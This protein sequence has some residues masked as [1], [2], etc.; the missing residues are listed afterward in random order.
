MQLLPAFL[1]LLIDKL[2]S[3]K[4]SNMKIFS[5]IFL[6][7]LLILIL[8]ADSKACSPLNVPTL[9]SQSIS[10][11]NLV[12]NWSGNTIYTCGYYLQV[13]LACNT[14]A[15]TGTGVPAF[16]NTATVTPSS[17]PY[18]YPTQNI[19]IST[20]CA[21]TT[22]KFRAREVYPASTFSAWTATFTFT[23]P[24][25]FISPTVSITAT[26]S[27]ICVPA[28]SQL[29]AT[30]LNACGPTTPIYSWTPT[31]GLSNPSIPNPIAS[32]TVTTT[33]TCLVTGGALG[34][35]TA[36]SSVTITTTTAPVPGTASVTPTSICGGSPVTLTLS[37][38]TGS[39]Q[40]Q[41]APVSGG[42]FTNIAGATTTPYV[43]ASLSSNTCF[44]A[45][46][47]G[48]SSANSNVVCV[49]I[50]PSPT[51]TVN[52]PTICLGESAILTGTG[53]TN[54]SWSTGAIIN[55]INVAPIATTSYT[56]TGSIGGCT[57]TAVSTVTVN[58]YPVVAVN[59]ATICAGG[60][61]TLTATGAT[62]YV[63]DDG[64]T[65]NPITVS[66]VVTTTY[67]VTGTTSS[68]SVT[69]TSTVTVSAGMVANAGP[70]DT[71]CFDENTTLNASPNG[72]GY[73][74]A[75]T[76]AGTL[77]NPSIYN[78]VASPTTTTVYYVTITDPGGCVGT[79]SV[80]VYADPQINL[81]IAGID[82]TCNGL[83]NGQTIVIP[84][85]GTSGYT[86]NWSSGCTSASCTS[87]CAGSY[88]VTVTDS[89]GCTSTADTSVFQPTLLTA[90][91]TGSTQ[92]TC[93]GSCDATVTASGAG[94]TPGG[95][96]AYSWNTVPVQPTATVTGLC[97]G[98]YTCTITDA[99]GCTATTVA[100]ITQPTL[101][102]V[103]PIASVTIC[104]GASTT[105][106]AS[107]SGGNPGGYNYVWS[108][109][110]TGSTASVTV[111][112]TSTTVYTVNASDIANSCPAAAVNVTVTV[113]P[114]L[115]LV[116]N[117]TASIC[118]GS[119]T[120][121][122]ATASLGNGGPYTYS[123][124]PAAGLSSASSSNPSANPASTTTYTV[125][126]NDG[127][128]PSVTATVTVTVNP[129]PV[130]SF[131]AD[132]TSGCSPL[133]V[134]FTDNSTVTGGVITTWFWNFGDGATSVLQTPS[135]CYYIAGSYT[136]A[137]TVTSSVGGCTSTATY[138]NYITVFADP[139][140][141]FTAPM[142]AS[143]INP[144]INF[145]NNSSADA[146]SWSWDFGEPTAVG[147]T[148]SSSLQHPTHT[149]FD[150]GTYCVTL[151]VT[152]SN[153]CVDD[154][155][156]CLVIDPEFTFYI[157]NAF[158]PNDDGIND[159]FYG[160]GE[161]IITFEMSV[162]DRWGNLIFFSDDINKHWNGKA[163]NGSEIAQQDVYVYVVKLKDNK[164]KKHKYIGTV[165]L[166]K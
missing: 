49:T 28:T 75:W 104:S 87:L 19:N 165:T 110:G 41:S 45:V 51:V 114:L 73:S 123:W 25:T 162:F 83:C 125:T 119:S 161:F 147:T 101:V 112:P 166:V 115:S 65:T 107:A 153:G 139:V 121:I 66:P 95:G 33:Y 131:A 150:V 31:T 78:P 64:S 80:T 152:S 7:I 44:R 3:L 92:T 100:V 151:T 98:S 30:V 5:Q 154:T 23:T 71:I 11:S 67:T 140:A 146:T 155:I 149:Y 34:C 159:E 32:P 105:L 156:Q 164:D 163:N 144:E 12:L 36:T 43:T 17:A 14:S 77:S 82:V 141:S 116:A 145:V 132:F 22:Y 62:S 109:A 56:V 70:N 58:P 137:L 2:N 117:G 91:N 6:S 127:C 46:V 48:C 54:Y 136:V 134:E 15:F 93:N 86:Y 4:Y 157:P 60:S 97:A 94:G 63:W 8:H 47:T 88:T 9:N 68:C 79:D 158:S 24:G 138:V 74:F 35:W 124:L 39:I 13:E 61:A 40:W 129:L 42:P 72:A 89:W 38:Y 10:G 52:S 113:N 135:H 20:L 76:P 96:Y 102:V 122:S 37:G 21:G 53:A 118:P 111:S 128:S 81:A 103:A 29:N 57:A 90:S 106:T 108:P 85:G 16:Y 1:R 142:S 50:N 59:S 120:P 133:C 55:P 26:P 84:N 160:K 99:N 126:A 148:N 143:I 27:V 18:A 130:S 69:A